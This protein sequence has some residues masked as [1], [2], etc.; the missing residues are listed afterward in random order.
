MLCSFLLSEASLNSFLWWCHL[1]T[2]ITL[3][4][5]CHIPPSHWNLSIFTSTAIATLTSHWEMGGKIFLH[6]RIDILNT[7]LPA[8]ELHGTLDSMN[9]SEFV[10]FQSLQTQCR[11]KSKVLMQ[12]RRMEFV[13]NLKRSQL[14]AFDYFVLSIAPLVRLLS[15]G[16]SSE[17]FVENPFW[18]EV[19]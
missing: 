8:L 15:N 18:K 10:P 17:E 5:T 13:T 6:H 1:L 9:I 14:T 16:V 3:W 19:C 11:W 12:W 2:K 4:K 7:P